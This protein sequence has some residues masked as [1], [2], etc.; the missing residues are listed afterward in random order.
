M[1]LFPSIS[2]KSCLIIVSCSGRHSSYVI[3][4]LENNASLPF[5]MTKLLALVQKDKWSWKRH[6]ELI[7][8]MASE[9]RGKTTPV[10]NVHHDI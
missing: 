3:G 2:P 7:T 8:K 5:E 4:A 1:W 6:R 10:I 9:G